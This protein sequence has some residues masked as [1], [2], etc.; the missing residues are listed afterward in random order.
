MRDCHL[1]AGGR[2]QKRS[3]NTDSS[4][5]GTVFIPSELVA[6]PTILL[7]PNHQDEASCGRRCL[8]FIDTLRRDTGLASAE[9]LDA[10]A[11][12][13]KTSG[14]ESLGRLEL[15]HGARLDDE[16]VGATLSRKER[17]N[18]SKDIYPSASRSTRPAF[19]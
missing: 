13:I 5:L 15:L 17:L 8:S 11:C 6:C 10:P 19:N 14:Q 9:E 7:E 16:D 3:A 4:L 1:F 12:W 18:I 2:L